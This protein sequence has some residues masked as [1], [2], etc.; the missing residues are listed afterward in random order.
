M[1]I[2]LKTDIVKKGVENLYLSSTNEIISNFR[3]TIPLSKI[4]CLLRYRSAL[5]PLIYVAHALACNLKVAL[6]EQSIVNYS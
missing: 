2:F 6:G 1:T 5:P 4:M 3:E